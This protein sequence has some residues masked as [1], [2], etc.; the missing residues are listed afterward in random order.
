MQI[1]LDPLIV[2]RIL[3]TL[4][5]AIA[6]LLGGLGAAIGIGT[7]GSAMIG[8]VAERPETFSKAMISVVLAEALGIYGLLASFMIVMRLDLIDNVAKGMTALSSGVCIGVAALASGYSISKSGAAMCTAIARAPETFSKALVSVVLAEA[9]AIYGLLASF[10]IIM[11]IDAVTNIS[12]A[13]MAVASAL[14]IGAAAV[15]AGISI[16]KVG[17]SLARTVAEAPATFSKGLVPV[18]LAEALAIYGLLVSFM[19]VMRIET[20][21]LMAE[22]VLALSAGLGIGVSALGGGYG[23]A[24]AGEVLCRSLRHA[25]ETFSK[26]LVAVVLAEALSIYGLL[27]AF[28]LV[29][30][31]APTVADVGAFTGLSAAITVG[32]GGLFAGLAI[33]IA[34][35]AMVG[36]LTEKPAIF[37]KAM[38][39][40]VLAEALAIYCLL[41]GFMLIMQI[42]P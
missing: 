10:M 24:Q 4:G 37:S 27:A 6:A 1:P 5:A 26:S 18:V 15:A 35:K 33:G 12:Q 42:G 7:G 34:G 41:V 2:T 14:A 29:M 16:A 13:W 36:A 40:V 31:I 32:F 19:I 21:T 9:L 3:A 17:A 20:T 39:P 23:I 11:R 28:M 30:R 25:P 8:T 22:A 38:V